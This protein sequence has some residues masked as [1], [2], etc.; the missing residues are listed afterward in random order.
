M[1]FVTTILPI[2]N[3]YNISFYKIIVRNVFIFKKLP[4]DIA[5]YFCPTNYIILMKL[6][7]VISLI[8]YTVAT[9]FIFLY[10]FIQ[11]HLLYGYLKGKKWQQ[12]R[13]K[14]SEENGNATMPFVSIQLPMFNEPFVCKRL[15]DTVCNF[16]YPT[17][18]F[19]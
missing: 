17:T 6:F 16:N 3:G 5:A 15:I 18:N 19:G 8:V 13:I 10:T 14:T 7:L 12:Q 11:V 2:E 1:R 4:S 9:L